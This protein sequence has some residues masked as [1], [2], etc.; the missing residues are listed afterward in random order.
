MIEVVKHDHNGSA[1][2]YIRHAIK[3]WVFFITLLTFGAGILF[4][5]AWQ[6]R[7]E[8]LLGEQQLMLSEIARI[9]RERISWVEQ[10]VA[11]LVN[12]KSMTTFV[13]SGSQTDRLRLLENF[14]T[15]M[16]A[17]NGRY[18]QLRFID[19]NGFEKLRIDEISGKPSVVADNQLQNKRERFYFQAGMKLEPEQVYLSRFDLNVE[20]GKI[21]VPYKPVL[22]LVGRVDD[23]R[24][25]KKGIVVLNFLGKSL[26]SDLQSIATV[27]N[28]RDFWLLDQDGYWLDGIEEEREWGFMFDDK[29]AIT[30]S[31]QNPD[32]WQKLINS[33]ADKTV[34][35][36][37]DDEL[38]TGKRFNL[39]RE[40]S[41]AGAGQLVAHSSDWYLLMRLGDAKLHEQKF[42][43]FKTYLFLWV[44]MFLIVT[45][46]SYLLGRQSF[47]RNLA[48]DN[49]IDA[50]EKLA[51]TNQELETFA[52][53]VSHDLRSPLLS[54]NG[55]SRILQ[56]RYADK[57]DAKGQDLLQRVSSSAERMD[58]LID[59]I[60]QLSRLSR[61]GV[62]NE[63]I[64]LSSMVNQKLALL[65]ASEPQR[66]VMLKVEKNIKAIADAGLLGVAFDNLLGNAWKFTGRTGQAVIEFG[67]QHINGRQVYFI[68]DNGAGFDMAHAEKLFTPFQRLHHQQEFAGTGIGLA[69]VQRV[70][71][72]H[73]GEI[74]AESAV[75]QATT[76]YFTLH[77]SRP[78]S[79][80]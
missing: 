62:N 10:D 79:Q 54:I 18:A 40:L 25:L 13:E 19:L 33:S 68:R 70:I 12:Q 50:N 47:K 14:S 72:K 21:E 23:S 59:D 64:D 6:S 41:T 78:A 60:L 65:V 37:S 27:Y 1:L 22:R 80:G 9:M 20:H 63:N 48:V 36:I 16:T 39:A 46:I 17:R 52:Y 55:F 74:W 11:Y 5:N 3:Y 56:T 42:G 66:T 51:L 67:R 32:F 2:S 38:I 4:Y 30:F 29:K 35:F 43:L 77:E 24:G 34:N 49:M 8:T 57:L 71:F 69:T 28:E 73:D 7:Q 31:R 76:F 75:D 45:F 61:A 58:Q 53:S 26:L 15:M 44:L